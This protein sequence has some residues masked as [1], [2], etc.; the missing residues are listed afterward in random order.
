[1]IPTK[2]HTHGTGHAWYWTRTLIRRLATCLHSVV[3]RDVEV[4][5]VLRV[6]VNLCG[7]LK[8]PVHVTGGRGANG[9]TVCHIAM[10]TLY[11]TSLHAISAPPLLHYMPSPALHHAA[12]QHAH[13][14]TWSTLA[15]ETLCQG[16]VKGCKGSV[17]GCKVRTRNVVVSSTGLVQC[18]GQYGYLV[19][20]RGKHST[21]SALRAS[22][23][24]GCYI[25]PSCWVWLWMR[26][27]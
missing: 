6:D 10:A 27:R 15:L 3:A 19:T 18:T 4:R 22:Y 2:K 5:D 11:A 25:V 17:H 8:K 23:G 16:E 1:M 21:V 13:G 12:T 9:N 14:S 24:Y 20:T 26:T 7:I